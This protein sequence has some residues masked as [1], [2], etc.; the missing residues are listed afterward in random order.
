[1]NYTKHHHKQG[2]TKEL[3]GCHKPERRE[4]LQ[5]TGERIEINHKDGQEGLF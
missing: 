3:K 4:Q 5:K 1:M 2:G